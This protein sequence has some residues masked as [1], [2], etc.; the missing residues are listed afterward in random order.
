MPDLNFA[1]SGAEAVS[2]AAAPTIAFRLHVRNRSGEPLHSISLRCQLQIESPKRRY[3]EVE[4]AGLVDLFGE[5]ARWGQTLRSL[6]WTNT[7]TVVGPFENDIE[8]DL[9]VACTYDFNVA[10][11]KYFDALDGGD[12]PLLFLFSGTVF[13]AN[14]DGAL[15]IEQI[16]WSRECTFRLPVRVWKEMMSRYYPN[17]AWLCLRKDVFDRLHE[18]KMQRGIPTWEQTLESILP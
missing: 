17:T 2:N 10:V 7:S 13:Y 15:Q 1:V 3:S 9:P 12:V 18:Y 5:T 14:A 6:L 4:C 16:P 11:A 8:T